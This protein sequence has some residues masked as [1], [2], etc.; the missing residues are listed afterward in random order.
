GAYDAIEPAGLR[1]LREAF[2]VLGRGAGEP[3][4]RD[5]RVGEA[6]EDRHR[7]EQWRGRRRGHR[8]TRGAPQ[9]LAAARLPAEPPRAHARSR[10]ASARDGVGN[11]VELEVE[12]DFEAALVQALDDGRAF[13]DEELLADLYSAERRIEARGQRERRVRAGHVERDNDALTVQSA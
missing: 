10:A 13:G 2:G 6:R 11:V 3:D 9:R 1:E 8:L 7:D 5:V 4:L 12:E